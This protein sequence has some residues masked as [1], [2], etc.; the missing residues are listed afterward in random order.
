[1]A[2][3][4]PA[5][6]NTPA[7]RARSKARSRSRPSRPRQNSSPARSSSPGLPTP[8]FSP[9]EHSNGEE[10]VDEADTLSPFDPRR[11]TPTLH[12]SLVSEILS[13]RRDVENKTKAID[14]LE[15][16]LDESRI[17]GETL[18]ANLSHATREARSL[19][20]QIQLLE[21]G[22]SSAMT[23]LARERDEAVENITD[24]RKKLEQVQKRA[25]SREEEAERT[26]ML[27]D[28][29]RE[30]WE[31][32][33]RN[34]ER[35]VHVVE[36]RLKTVLNE[37]A[38]AQEAGNL[39]SQNSEPDGALSNQ[40]K[41]SDTA[42]V[43]SSGKGHRRGSMASLTSEEGE[44]EGEN[45][46][47]AEYHNVRYSIMSAAPGPQDGS[48]LNLA[49][50]LDFDEEDEFAASDDDEAPESPEALAEERPVSVHSQG[51]HTVASKARKILGLSIQS[52]D[53]ATAAASRAVDIDGS[54]EMPETTV[55]YQDMGIQYS[56]P[57]SPEIPVPTQ[58]NA[59]S[60]SAETGNESEE[61]VEEEE[62][63]EMKDT[64]TITIGIEM[65]STSCQTIGNLPSPPWTPKI[66]E[67]DSPAQSVEES[68]KSVQMVSAAIQTEPT[69]EMEPAKEV[70]SSLS[71]NDIPAEMDIPMITIHPPGSEPASP[72]DSVVLPPQ[73]KNVS[74]QT[75][76]RS[77]VE[78]RSIAIQTEEIRIDTRKLPASLLPSAIQD[79]P[80]R[81]EAENGNIQPYRAPV[82]P[83]RSAKRE[84]R[85]RRIEPPTYPPPPPPKA[86]PAQAYPGNN[87]NGP[88]SDD[89]G[90]GI[91]RPFR[92]SSLFAGF[93]QLSD[94]ED[95]H[96]EERDIFTD[97]ELL[98]RPFAA[99]KIRR[100][101]LVNAA[102][103]RTS[104]DDL[105]L[106]EID[107]H[108]SDPDWRPSDTG[109]SSSR[110][111]QRS[112]AT[113]ASSRQSGMRK[114]AMVS[115][116][117]SAHQKTR[118]R[119][120]SEPSLDSVSAGSS[121]APPFPVPMRLSSRNIPLHGSDGPPSPTRSAG[122][123]FSD[124][125]QGSLARRP[126]LRRVRSAAAM[127]QSD[128][129]DRSELHESPVQS[130][131][132]F[133]ADGPSYRLPRMPFDDYPAPQDL[134]KRP[135]HQATTSVNWT[136]ERRDSTG[137]IQ[138]T[139]VVDAIAQTMVGEWMF[140]YVRR[141]KSFSMSDSKDSW[142]GKNADEVSANITNSGA[143][144]K[145]WVWLAPYEGSI[146]WSSKQPTS[147]PALLGKSG[148]KCQ[149]FTSDI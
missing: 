34:L 21:G 147:G 122:R 128:A 7:S 140:K 82:P 5:P 116:G 84:Q 97:D 56:P 29:D 102:K 10:E 144:H 20:H 142:E 73:T 12:A 146:M 17:E 35:K 89:A 126:T 52:T 36:G 75:N 33:R 96:G 28:R 11:I 22:S 24:V 132:P 4:S 136:H 85:S 30:N 72:R 13:L 119:S 143:R 130:V 8:A 123:H 111:T 66:P 125:G 77:V 101:K 47:Q 110:T 3:P 60:G 51:S 99:Y 93:E 59:E 25:R 54:V 91:R 149:Y 6:S 107:E 46:N 39:H 124:R 19:R 71:P 137:G 31:N 105:G 61:E 44:G 62:T 120:P 26:Q 38:A 68:A 42:S 139:S 95:P 108:L 67:P 135:S 43:A 98:N 48:G 45:E 18:S 118:A 88:L 100:G 133:A 106:P 14:S 94:D 63:P 115:N 1:M 50:E 9:G 64:A 83:P 16:S 131:H 80:P 55:Q 2:H 148:R 81:D 86:E 65:V 40:M 57:P 53:S 32:E 112:G 134:P 41:T 87:D 129:A 90:S 109:R 113:A 141:R 37:V 121:I 103:S 49:Q 114:M 138:P 15:L 78:G 92:S 27:W 145:R 70:R 23:E 69:A 74:V 58:E 127:S 104:W 76:F 117:A 79:V